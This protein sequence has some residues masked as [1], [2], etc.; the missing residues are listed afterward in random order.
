VIGAGGDGTIR[1][2][3]DGL[4]GTGIPLGIIP[5]GTGNLLAR[6][7]N[8]ALDEDTALEIALG[9]RTRTID[10]ILLTVDGGPPEHF[11][12]MAGVGVDAMIMNETDPALKSKIGAGA[13]VVAAG[14]ALGRLPIKVTV[15]VDGHRPLHRHAM[16]CLI[17]NVG[18]LQGKI[19]LIADAEPDDGLLDVYIASPQRLTHWLKVILRMISRRPQKDDRVDQLKGRS[20]TIKIDGRDDYQLDGDGIG[21]CGLM[22]A[23]VR[24]GTLLL[25]VP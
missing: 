4:A 21:T 23:E 13:Y 10:L 19:T 20:V 14:K 15:T 11:A 3:A 1:L 22:K 6:N 9:D 16:L 2:I 12:V 8:L 25:R 7:L 17:G 24:P 18:E 5:A